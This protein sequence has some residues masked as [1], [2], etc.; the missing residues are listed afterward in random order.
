MRLVIYGTFHRALTDD[1]SHSVWTETDDEL[2][3]GT[4]WLCAVSLH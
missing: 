3:M 2:L 4:L 1:A